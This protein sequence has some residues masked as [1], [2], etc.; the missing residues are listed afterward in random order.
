MKALLWI[1]V[2][3]LGLCACDGGRAKR[4]E[5]ARAERLELIGDVASLKEHIR[6]TNQLLTIEIDHPDPNPVVAEMR[7]QRLQDKIDE[8][9][10]RL[11]VVRRKL[12]KLD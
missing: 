9:E 12:K 8:A 5:D 10:D 11:K 2:A 4:L 6:H 1:S 7:I 3:A